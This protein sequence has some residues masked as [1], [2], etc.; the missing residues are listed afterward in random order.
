MREILFRGKRVDNGEWVEGYYVKELCGTVYILADEGDQWDS[1]TMLTLVEIDE[2]TVGQFTGL[3]DKNG[4]KIFGGDV[5]ETMSK[6]YNVE[7][8]EERGGWFP[9]AVDDGCGCCAY[10]TASPGNVAIIGNIHDGT[11]TS[12]DSTHE[13]NHG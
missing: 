8:K 10:N 5:V 1:Q 7:F 3:T 6:H 4:V 11:D 13:V 9:F 12:V 2:S